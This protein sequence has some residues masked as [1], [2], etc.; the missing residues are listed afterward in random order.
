MKKCT[1]FTGNGICLAQKHKLGCDHMAYDE[2]CRLERGHT[3]KHEYEYVGRDKGL[4][5]MEYEIDPTSF[6]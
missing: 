2:F 4:V 5:Q 6:R 1:C 3:G